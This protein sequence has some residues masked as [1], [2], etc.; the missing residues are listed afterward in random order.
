[1]RRGSEAGAVSRQL[2]LLVILAQHE[3]LPM[4]LRL[5]LTH[6]EL[7]LTEPRLRLIEP[8]L[9]PIATSST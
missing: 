3:L 9:Q 2:R 6:P 5:Y 1:M 8:A 7:K 4:E